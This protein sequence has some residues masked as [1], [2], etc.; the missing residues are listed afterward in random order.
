MIPL[1]KPSCGQEE[2]DAVTAVLQSGWW[3]MGKEVEKFEEEFAHWTRTHYAVATNSCTSAL[4]L[5]ARALS[6]LPTIAIVPSFTFVSTA[7]AMMHAGHS[8]AFADIDETEL[9]M[10]WDDVR[11]VISRISV[12]LPEGRKPIVVPVWYAGRVKPIPEDIRATAIVIEDCAHAAGSYGAGLQGDAAC[13]SFQAVKNLA[14][15]DGGMITL[16][17]T[18]TM[19]DQALDRKLRRLR[20]CGI[21]KSTWERDKDGALG[22]G[23]DYDIPEDGYKAHMNDL[24]AALGR[25]QLRYLDARNSSRYRICY[26]YR[27]AL[28]GTD[29]LTAPKPDAGSSNHLYYIRVAPELRPRLIEH[30]INNGVS[31]GVHYKPLNHYK[32]LFPD[33]ENDTPVAERVWQELV[34]LPVYPDLTAAETKTVAAVIKSFKS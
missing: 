1:F 5:A 2:I 18:E 4:E 11:Q 12:L 23:W 34:T 14:T 15:G 27:D 13:W 6:P 10:D 28:R 22:Y 30:M 33:T 19:L 32:A 16:T 25:A 24:T 29:W 31:A 8:I 9:T 3:G 7:Q 26:D 21:D 17:L 20:W